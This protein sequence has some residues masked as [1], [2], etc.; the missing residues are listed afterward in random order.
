MINIKVNKPLYTVLAYTEPKETAMAIRMCHDTGDQADTITLEDDIGY[1]NENE[2]WI[3]TPLGP[4]DKALIDKIGNKMKHASTLEHLRF[5]FVTN[6]KILIKPFKENCYSRVTTQE[7]KTGEVVYFVSSNIRA[8]I[9]S[10][11]TYNNIDL[12][13]LKQVIPEPYHYLIEKGE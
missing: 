12:D 8:V 9:E 5:V 7:K 11:V 2:E 1:I 3:S 6:D 13:K 4:K 10:I